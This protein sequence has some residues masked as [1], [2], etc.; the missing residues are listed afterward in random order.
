MSRKYKIN[1]KLF[2]ILFII[3]IFLI[4]A[5]QIFGAANFKTVLASQGEV[6]DGFWSEVLILRDEKVVKSPFSGKVELFVG[7]GNR[8]SAGE[9]LLKIRSSLQEQFIFNSEA[10]IVSFAFDGLENKIN[11]S[12]LKSINLNKIDSYKGD[13]HHLL[14][15]DMVSKNEPLYRVINNFKLYLIVEVPKKQLDRFSLNEL[16]FLAPKN[17][18]NLFKARIIDIRHNLNESYFYI[19]VDRF[20]PEWINRRRINLNIIKNIYRG[21]KIPRKAVFNLP[22]GKGVLKVSGY[23]KYDFQKVDIVDGNEK[24]VIVSGLKIGEEIIINPEDFDYGREGI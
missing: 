12:N 13:Y 16:I 18:E 6:I 8:L 9:K 15:G 14:T 24:N 5:I 17:S 7:E 21:I 11:I 10:G 2:V 19:A 1:F 23:N 3:I 22:S 20:I 4:L